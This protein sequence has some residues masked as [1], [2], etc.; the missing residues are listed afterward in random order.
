MAEPIQPYL[1]G[2]GRGSD[3][4]R[5]IY[6]MGSLESYG[7]PLEAKPLHA[8]LNPTPNLPIGFTSSDF[9]DTPQGLIDLQ[10]SVRQ[11]K[12]DTWNP[13]ENNSPIWRNKGG[14]GFDN[15]AGGSKVPRQPKPKTP[16]GGMKK[17]LV[18]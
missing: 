9:P 5:P 7:Q 12:K 10:K 2:F 14:K 4:H 8:P 17:A 11:W 18:K 6:G 13:H 16:S 15:P 3:R 1:A